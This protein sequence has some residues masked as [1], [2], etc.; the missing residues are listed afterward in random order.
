MTTFVDTSA[1]LALLDAD[2][3]RHAAAA[4]AW[5]DLLLADE[6]LLT[7]NYVLVECFALAQRRLGMAAARALEED[8]LPVVGVHWI[9]ATDHAA[10]VESFLT[11]ARRGLSLVD[12]TSFRVMRRLRLRR[13]FAFDMDFL[14][15]GFEVVPAIAG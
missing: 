13:A 5:R 6:P 11:A 12:C 10:A 2:E 7:S 3:E 4:D 9:D 15:Q 8:L 1:L 14:E